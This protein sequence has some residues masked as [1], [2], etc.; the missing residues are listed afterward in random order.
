ML[1]ASGWL[2]FGYLRV[3]Q[4]KHVRRPWLCLGRPLNSPASNSPMVISPASDSP[5]PL[6]HALGGESS[7]G[8][9]TR[10]GDGPDDRCGG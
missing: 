6:Q 9:A 3:K 7:T 1:L 4:P 8:K 10:I 5:R 2:Q